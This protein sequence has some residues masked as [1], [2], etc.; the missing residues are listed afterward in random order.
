LIKLM[1]DTLTLL[2]PAK[3][4]LF[5]HI[6][7]RRNDGYHLLQSVFQLI[8]WCDTVTLTATKN[9]RISRTNP[10][11][12][13]AEEE[14]LVVRAATLLQRKCQV[15]AGVEIKLTKELPVG[16]GL[17]GGSS[18]AASTLIGLNALWHLQLSRAQLMELGLELGADVPFFIHGSNA[19]VEGIGEI[20][21]EVTLPEQRF[22]VIFPHRS[23]ATKAL[24]AHPE[25]TRDHA[26][27]TIN[28]FLA[29]PL[30]DPAFINDCQ[31]VAAQICPEVQ[32]AI[33][34]ITEA[35]PGA[36]PQMSGSGSTVFAAIPRQAGAVN[37][38]SLLQ[39]LPRE[40]T[41]RI[42]RGI[43]KNPAY[44]LISSD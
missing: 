23:I 20:I 27:I 16:A 7:G 9:N 25:L 22:I 6:V 18:D 21:Q 39:N 44:N 8:D 5:L 19:F 13:I 12:G 40:W 2:A 26:P 41:G 33:D 43:N 15:P 35:L 30:P 24:F 36:K 31:A 1:T 10:V 4:N 14:D 3:L 42:V 32:H 17:G 37:L 11:V 29:S 28:G 34:W 38:D